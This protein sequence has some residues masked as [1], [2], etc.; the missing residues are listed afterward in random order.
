MIYRS[1]IVLLLYGT[2]SLLE[3][4]AQHFSGMNLCLYHDLRRLPEDAVIEVLLQTYQPQF[5]WREEGIL[6]VKPFIKNYYKVKATCKALMK[7]ATHPFTLGIVYEKSYPQVLSD[8]MLVNNNLDSAHAGYSPLLFPM[9]GKGVVMGIIDAGIDLMHADFRNPDSSTRIISLWDQTQPYDGQNPYGYGTVWDSS[10]INAGL[11]TS[12]DQQ[13]YYSH[14]TNVAG[15]AASNGLATGQYKGVAPK[16]DLVIVSSNFAVTNW[17]VTVAE[18]AAFI[19]SQADSLGKPCVINASIGTY[20]GSH[21]GTDPAA[22]YIDSLIKAKPGRAFVCAAGNSGHLKYHLGYILS[23]VDTNFSWFAYNPSTILGIPGMFFELWADTGQA[24]NAYFSLGFDNPS[25]YQTRGQT[26]YFTLA[27]RV[28]QLITDTIKNNNAEVIGIIQTWVEIQGEKYLMQVAVPEIDSISYH[29]V[30][31]ATGNG[32]F[33]VW[34]DQW[35]GYS[36]IVSTGLPSL[37]QY[38]VFQYYKMPDSLSTIVSSFT[39]LPTVITVGNYVNRKTYTD[40]NNILQVMPYTRGAASYTSSLGPTR[41]GLLKPDVCASGD[42]TLA[43]GDSATIAALIT[44]GQSFKVAQDGKHMRNGGTS[45][46]SP[47]VA[48]LCAL[49]LEKCPYASWSEIKNT[50]IQYAFSD[51]FTGSL[52]N[53]KWGNGKVNGFRSLINAYRNGNIMASGNIPFCAGDSVKLSAEPFLN[54]YTWNTTGNDSTIWVYQ[55]GSY[56][57]SATDTMGCMIYSDSISVNTILPP[58]PQVI[59]ANDTLYCTTIG[60]YSYQWYENGQPVGSNQNWLWLPVWNGLYYVTITDTAGCSATS[61]PVTIT[62]T[63]TPSNELLQVFPSP[64]S[65]HLVISASPYLFTE[66]T[67]FNSVGQPVHRQHVDGAVTVISTYSWATGIYLVTFS[68]HYPPI[69][70]VKER[71]R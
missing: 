61:S 24:T 22:L 38:P 71:E 19:F 16:T 39:C 40:Y 64:F 51:S 5:L 34:S 35:M 63:T 70:V 27:A 69:K 58:T 65:D 47:V 55:N 7:L 46:A 32:K 42:V 66:I 3:T 11:C 57:Y 48:G 10:Q 37:A 8:T 14:G 43:S 15:I 45:M 1:L 17:L 56:F 6:S 4:N 12:I 60:N 67:I 9:E 29:L 25:P 50:I 44:F 28:N 30:L 68:P 13:A 49:Y 41:K 18:A 59:Y 33:D 54:N 31:R 21:D 53:Y 52:P 20:S 26:G 23:P 36:H 62:Y 2:C